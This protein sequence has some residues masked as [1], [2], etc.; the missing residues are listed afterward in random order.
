[1]HGAAHPDTPCSAYKKQAH[2]PRRR[3]QRGHAA[4]GVRPLRRRLCEVRPRALL[5][6]LQLL[7]Q[8][9]LRPL[10]AAARGVHVCA[11]PAAV[12]PATRKGLRHGR[13]INRRRG[14]E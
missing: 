12:L 14:H 11:L 6:L 4:V 5:R 8:Q 7:L 1:M 3:H 9:L 10:L 2:L 13:R